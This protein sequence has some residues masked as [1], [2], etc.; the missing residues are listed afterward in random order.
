MGDT[1]LSAGAGLLISNEL[2]GTKPYKLENAYLGPEYDDNDIKEA[3]SKY[4]KKLPIENHNS[5]SDYAGELISENEIVFWHQGRME[6]GPRALG[7]RSILGSADSLDVK[8][9]LNMKVKQRSWYQP[10]CPTLLE[11]DAHKFIASRHNNKFMTMGYYVK[12]EIVQYAQSVMNIDNS[13]RPQILG[14]ENPKY[15]KV[16]TKVKKQSGYGIVLNTSFNVHGE[17]IV[18]SPNDAI[19]NLLKTKAKHLFIGNYYVKNDI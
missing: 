9:N 19:K 15:K 12:P 8:N 13:I 4:R 11:K 16:L 7:N 18:N 3:L 14:K 2:Y 1:G 17:P 6:F 5:V 10:F